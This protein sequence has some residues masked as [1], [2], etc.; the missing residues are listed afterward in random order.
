MLNRLSLL[1]FLFLSIL[2]FLTVLNFPLS[3][4][5]ASKDALLAIR[6]ERRFEPQQPRIG[7]AFP[8][9]GANGFLQAAS[10]SSDSFLMAYQ[11]NDYSIAFR[12]GI[13]VERGGTETVEYGEETIPV[14]ARDFEQS[15]KFFKLVA[16][17]NSQ[18]VLFFNFFD[19]DSTI[20]FRLINVDGKKADTPAVPNYETPQ[21]NYDN[22]SALSVVKLSNTSLAVAAVQNK[23]SHENKKEGSIAV[24]DF[25]ND[26]IKIHD[27]TR[28]IPRDNLGATQVTDPVIVPLTERSLIIGWQSSGNFDSQT[29]FDS[30]S[31]SYVAYVDY[32]D[33]RFHFYD[34]R[35]KVF[36]NEDLQRLQAQAL[37]D[38]KFLLLFEDITA[39]SPGETK[40]VI[41]SGEVFKNDIALKTESAFYIDNTKSI[42]LNAPARDAFTVDY[43]K[44][45]Y[46]AEHFIR[47]GELQDA[48]FVMGGEVAFN[49]VWKEKFANISYQFTRL[50]DYKFLIAYSGLKSGTFIGTLGRPPTPV[51]TDSAPSL[52]KTIALNGDKF[53][54]AYAEKKTGSA[55]W[56][57]VGAVRRDGQTSF[58]SPTDFSREPT[59]ALDAA[60]LDA[61][62]ILVMY[63]SAGKTRAVVGTVSGDEISYAAP[64]EI[65]DGEM[66]S[67]IH[68]IPSSQNKAVLAYRTQ[69]NYAVLRPIGINGNA[70][71]LGGEFIVDS[72]GAQNARFKQLAVAGAGANLIVVYNYQYKNNQGD[73]VDDYRL[74]AARVE[75]DK[76]KFDSAPISVE[77][78]QEPDAAFLSD[79]KFAV[80]FRAHLEKN[81]GKLIVGNINEQGAIDLG[82]PFIFSE[83]QTRP[84]ALA[85]SGE[86]VLALIYGNGTGSITNP[87]DKSFV[88]LVTLNGANVATAGEPFALLDEKSRLLS[89]CRL[90]PTD[91]IF[92][93]SREGQNTAEVRVARANLSG[94]AFTMR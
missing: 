13:I 89:I 59:F 62:R 24:I 92:A 34:D 81:I 27:Q 14:R 38:K 87:A 44:S 69:T 1:R 6:N 32:Y 21:L 22:L 50:S 63:R 4:A 48:D 57:R 15:L 68:I 30:G 88:R 61:S 91:F 2:V 16:L 66:L 73:Y 64:T 74:R 52:L 54:S 56:T 37:T 12:A 40:T 46:G 23:S 60:A 10:L 33:N 94:N 65:G 42:N 49:S 7:E 72:A 77:G 75:A 36:F 25:V 8:F 51:I 78:F 26:E 3:T 85:K 67:D 76:I 93:F 70:I 11:K 84:V 80:V 82:N 79:T 18:A 20:R 39:Y 29:G 45:D 86:N 55:G 71:D 17:N 5:A 53:V 47:V 83:A 35:I 43:K 41:M 28:F 58:G 90:T 31:K 19:G 9:D